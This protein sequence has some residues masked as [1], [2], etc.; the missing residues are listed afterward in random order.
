MKPVNKLMQDNNLV[1]G[2]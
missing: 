2:I 1:H